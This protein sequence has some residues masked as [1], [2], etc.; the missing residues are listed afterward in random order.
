MRICKE[1][2]T[3]PLKGFRSQMSRALIVRNTVI[4]NKIVNKAL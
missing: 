4:C 1:T 3:K 2:V